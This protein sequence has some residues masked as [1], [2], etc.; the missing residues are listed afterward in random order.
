MAEPFDYYRE[1]ALVPS[2]ADSEGFTGPEEFVPLPGIGY[3]QPLATYQ[4]PERSDAGIAFSKGKRLLSGSAETLFKGFTGDF[5]KTLGFEEAGDTWLSD[6]YQSGI[7]MGIDVNELDSQLKGPKTLEEIE[8]WKGAIAW[9]MNAVAEQVPNLVTTFAPAIIGTLILRRPTIGTVGTLGTIDFLNT[10]EVYTDL[11]MSTGESRP[12]VAAATG[13]LMS[14]LDMIVPMKVIGRM[15]KG[16]DF[17]SWFGGKLKDP[18]SG[19]AVGFGKAIGSGVTEG[20]TEYIQTMMEGMA[21]NYVQ[22]KDLLTE[23]SEAQRAEQLESGARGALIGT[24]LGIPISYQG[25]SARR[26]AEKFTK[27]AAQQRILDRLGAQNEVDQQG[28][29]AAN[30]DLQG[31][32]LGELT[33]TSPTMADLVEQRRI[34]QQSI[35]DGPITEE[36]FNNWVRGGKLSDSRLRKIGKKS[37]ANEELDLFETAIFSAET[38]RINDIIRQLASEKQA[39]DRFKQAT[40]KTKMS[41]IQAILSRGNV[42][43]KQLD[44][45][46]ELP[47]STGIGRAYLDNVRRRREEAQRAASEKIGRAHV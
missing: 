44:R 27:Q 11:L 21:L 29:S 13:T 47:L 12:A 19:F 32:Q 35:F 24:L 45:L 9:G 30:P 46:R 17:A 20:T 4:P 2:S 42:D 31:F 15:G 33:V 28:V 38:S 6:A 41:S 3:T 18:K 8:D 25:F 14:T 43:V 16:P 40:A 7:L 5:L 23:F 34:E 1:G 36:E 26:K 10:A 37:I 39:A 22:E